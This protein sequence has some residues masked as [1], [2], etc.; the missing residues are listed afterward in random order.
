MMGA[1]AMPAVARLARI[2]PVQARWKN[3]VIRLDRRVMESVPLRRIILV[4][5]LRA[6][7]YLISGPGGESMDPYAATVRVSFWCVTFVIS[8]TNIV[9]DKHN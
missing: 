3:R 7:I 6:T 4:L 8:M 2:T 5:L 1:W 9:I